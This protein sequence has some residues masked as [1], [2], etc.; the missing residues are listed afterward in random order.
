MQAPFGALLAFLYDNSNLLESLETLIRNPN[1]TSEQMMAFTKIDPRLQGRLA[2]LLT[3]MQNSSVRDVIM[4]MI[5]LTKNGIKGCQP[6]EV[7]A[8]SMALTDANYLCD[9]FKMPYPVVVVEIPEGCR[10]HIRVMPRTM[11]EELERHYVGLWGLDF[12]QF[13]LKGAETRYI[14]LSEEIVPRTQVAQLGGWTERWIHAQIITSEFVKGELIKESKLIYTTAN[15]NLLFNPAP[16]STFTRPMIEGKAVEEIITYRSGERDNSP[17]SIDIPDDDV[18][19]KPNQKWSESSEIEYMVRVSRMAMNVV[20]ALTN[21]GFDEEKKVVGEK[22]K[23][24]GSA[25]ANRVVPDVLRPVTLINDELDKVQYEDSEGH[26]G[27]VVS[28]HF[29]RGHWRRQ[30]YGEKRSLIKN[31]WIAP[32]IVNKHLLR[33]AADQNVLRNVKA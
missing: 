32:T 18:P 17:G 13:E 28:P 30:H 25:K 1:A 11:P 9:D 31:A 21:I 15:N 26:S 27:V 24:R 29:R 14:I 2:T 16:V 20:M 4:K 5:E 7:F 10:G 6:S 12:R 22:L 8:D 19:L 23:R 33:G 3:A